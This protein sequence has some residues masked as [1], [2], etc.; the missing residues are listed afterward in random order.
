M[1]K[2]R[3]N[4]MAW[5]ASISLVAFYVGDRWGMRADAHRDVLDGLSRAFS[6]DLLWDI[7]VDPLKISF[8]G[9]PLLCGFAF[10][11]AVWYAYLYMSGTSREVRDGDEY[12]SA[13]LGDTSDTSGY[14]DRRDRSNN[15]ILSKNVRMAIVPDKRVRKTL[16]SANVIVYGSSGTGKTTGYV[17]PNILQ[18]ADRDMVVVD[19]KG[20]TLASL[21]HAL[22]EAGYAVSVLDTVDMASSD[23]YNPLAGIRDYE[24]AIDFAKTLVRVVN[25]NRTGSE[26]IWEQGAVLF[27]RA[28]VTLMLD[29]FDREDMDFDHLVGLI[30]LA[31]VPEGDEGGKSP[32]DLIFD[33]IRTGECWVA[34]DEPADADPF[35]PKLA[36]D[37]RR[38][39]LVRVPS[40]MERRDGMRPA[41][42]VRPGGRHG[43]DDDEALQVWREF[44]S[45]PQRTLRSFLITVFASMGHLTTPGVRRLMSNVGETDELRLDLLGMREDECGE[46][47]PPRVVF[48]VSSDTSRSLR[49]IVSLAMWQAVRLPVRA[50]MRLPARRLP[51]HV[52]IVLDEFANVGELEGFVQAVSVVRSRNMNVEIILQSDSQLEDVYGERS[53]RTI[54]ANCATKVLLG[55]VRDM[56]TARMFSEELGKM[57]VYKRESS[58]QRS[59]SGPSSS[60]SMTSLSRDV[61]LMMPSYDFC[62]PGKECSNDTETPCD[63]FRKIRFPVNEFFPPAES[64]AQEN[65]SDGFDPPCCCG[66]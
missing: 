27:L 21:G 25:E 58:S 22:V 53:A 55:G 64:D 10:F 32:L 19:P 4:P 44:K 42:Q 1:A 59:A 28:I 15:I 29:W 7:L 45:S 48:V 40:L 50:A 12:G 31:R 3:L 66:R 16:P 38:G 61:Q 20:Q 54:R 49:P 34:D 57:T 37:R 8:D 39:G 63:S 26:P 11:V 5:A 18:M 9:A 23:R 62:M 2:S 52:S 6:A 41:Q 17:M 46:P 47:L 30:S 33:Q 35:A 36:D 65:Q 60:E 13:R 51:R 56:G 24:D 14:A 43:T